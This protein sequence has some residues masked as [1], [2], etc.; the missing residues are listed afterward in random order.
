MRL[1]LFVLFVVLSTQLLLAEELKE[2]RTSWGC[3]KKNE[4]FVFVEWKVVVSN[5]LSIPMRKH[6]CYG[7]LLNVAAIV[8]DDRQF[9]SMTFSFLTSDFYVPLSNSVVVVVDHF[10]FW[11]LV[12]DCF[13]SYCFF[14]VSSCFVNRSKWLSKWLLW[15]WC[16]FGDEPMSMR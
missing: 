12:F 14:Y 15:S 3:L 1:A 13:N 7:F 6:Y 16:M 9:Y 8:F 4:L 2:K 5:K 10:I 11:L